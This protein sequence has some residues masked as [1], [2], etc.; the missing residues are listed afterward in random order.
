M[1]SAYNVGRQE[2]V[3]SKVQLRISTEQLI[4]Q[5]FDLLVLGVLSSLSFESY[6]G[7]SIGCALCGF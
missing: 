2:H 3:F 1:G 6:S 4:T 7:R 5:L